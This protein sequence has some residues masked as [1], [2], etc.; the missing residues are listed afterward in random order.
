[1]DRCYSQ[2][3]NGNGVRSGKGGIESTVPEVWE[4]RKG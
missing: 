2:S 4:R 3:G 1:M